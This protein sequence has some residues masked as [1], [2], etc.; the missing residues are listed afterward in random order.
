LACT[1]WLVVHGEQ[2]GRIDDHLRDKGKE[3]I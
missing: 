3:L 1:F 2:L